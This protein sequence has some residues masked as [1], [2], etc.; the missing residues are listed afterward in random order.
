MMVIFASDTVVW[1]KITLPLEVGQDIWFGQIKA[2]HRL[3]YFID[4]KI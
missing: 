1:L 3:V 4:A 2:H